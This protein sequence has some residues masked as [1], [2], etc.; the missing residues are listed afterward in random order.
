MSLW[1][2][3]APLLCTFLV[4][5][6]LDGQTHYGSYLLG[7]AGLVPQL[8]WA[9]LPLP[10]AAALAFAFGLLLDGTHY[11]LPFGLSA[12]FCLGAIFCL[13]LLQQH[14]FWNLAA[15]SLVT[16]PFVTTAYYLT[17]SAALFRQTARAAAL[18]ACL[19][20][21]IFNC[22]MGVIFIRLSPEKRRLPTY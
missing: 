21:C 19:G 11:S 14:I 22:L 18:A 1:R 16:I 9:A 7:T 4:A 13:Q 17:L 12:F 20:S 5:T 10:S 2:F 3:V 15:K 8:L 6:V